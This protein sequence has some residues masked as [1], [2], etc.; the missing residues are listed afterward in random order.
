M[1]KGADAATMLRASFLCRMGFVM[2]LSLMLL[3]CCMM[4]VPLWV[5]LASGSVG[6]GLTLGCMSGTGWLEGGEE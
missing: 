3:T 6:I 2:G 1:T 5:M 4:D